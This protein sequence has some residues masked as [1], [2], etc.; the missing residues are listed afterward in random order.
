[1]EN[2]INI[3]FVHFRIPANH[4]STIIFLNHFP[5]L[6]GNP[7]RLAVVHIRQLCNSNWTN[8]FTVV[9]S[10]V[11]CNRFTGSSSGNLAEFENG[12]F[13]IFTEIIRR[14][15]TGMEI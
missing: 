4:I 6:S 5:V 14:D 13:P 7:G 3:I 1:M 10:F 15:V 2:P 11:F 12:L 9:I 8:S